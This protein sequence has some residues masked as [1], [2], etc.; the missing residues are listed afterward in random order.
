MM[1]LSS[2]KILRVFVLLLS[3]F[4]EG[5]QVQAEPLS[6]F[7][8]EITIRV[9]GGTAHIPF[10]QA[11]ANQISQKN[12]K[13]RLLISGGGSGVG[14]QKLGVGLVDIANTGRPLSAEEKKRFQL[15]SHAVA[16]DAIVLVVHPQNP[17]ANLSRQDAQ[18]IFAGEFTKLEKDKKKSEKG[19][20]HIYVRDEAS[21]TQEIFLEKVLGTKRLVRSANF[22]NSQGAMKMAVANDPAAIGF[23]S[24]G[25]LDDSV[26]ALS[27]AGVKAT[28]QTIQ[29]KSYPLV[30]TLYVNTKRNPG[31]HI[32]DFIK[33]LGTSE[34]AEV[35]S[36]WG[37]IPVQSSKKGR[38][39]S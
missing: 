6:I 11:L 29:Q 14:V 32:E 27:F 37:L 4:T 33:Y 24:F 26:K 10:M 36:K 35:I 34:S 7:R 22:T 25:Y 3:L 8:D 19:S 38:K 13:F 21:G 9:A 17:L 28:K 16:Q 15:V 23:L 12:P 20:F 30:R 2:K 39:K 31:R 18:K 5:E 1:L